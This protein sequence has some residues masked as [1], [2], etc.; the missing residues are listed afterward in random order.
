M[1]EFVLSS[2]LSSLI[3]NK[4]GMKTLDL[5]RVDAS[6]DQGV[7]QVLTLHSGVRLGGWLL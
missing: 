2:T 5:W 6:G 4:C 1:M 7:R 3:F